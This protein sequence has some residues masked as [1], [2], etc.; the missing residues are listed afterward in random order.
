MVSTILDT[1]YK[2]WNKYKMNVLIHFVYKNE[3]NTV[4]A[5][6][7]PNQINDNTYVNN[8]KTHTHK[9]IKYYHIWVYLKPVGF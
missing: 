3:W 2:I 1:E 6:K 8:F 7:E 5:L 4:I 9:P